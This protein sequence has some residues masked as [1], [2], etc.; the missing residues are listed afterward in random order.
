VTREGGPTTRVQVSTM[1]PKA[2]AAELAERA[3]REDRSIASLVRRAVTAYLA[4]DQR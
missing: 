2:E 3:C 4:A 1:L